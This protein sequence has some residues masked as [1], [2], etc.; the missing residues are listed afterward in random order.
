MNAGKGVATAPIVAH[1]FPPLGTPHRCCA[2]PFRAARS[3]RQYGKCALLLCCALIFEPVV[4][5]DFDKRNK[6]SP[7]PAELAGPHHI[8]STDRPGPFV[9]TRPRANGARNATVLHRQELCDQVIGL[10]NPCGSICNRSADVLGLGIAGQ[11]GDRQRNDGW[12]CGCERWH[13]QPRLAGTNDV[14]YLQN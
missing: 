9:A 2:E 12:R 1:G 10:S 6:L 3:R 7:E 5:F 11:V 14:W 13:S 4:N 8:T